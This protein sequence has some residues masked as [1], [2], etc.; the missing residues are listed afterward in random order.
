MQDLRTNAGECP[1]CHQSISESLIAINDFYKPM[2]IDQNIEFIQEQ[3]KIFNMMYQRETNS[4]EIQKRQIGSLKNHASDIRTAIRSLK[5]TL[6]SSNNSLSYATMEERIRLAEKIRYT[7]IIKAQ[8]DEL[9]GNF[10]CLAEEWCEVQSSLSKLPD[11]LLS[12]KDFSKIASLES[13]FQQQLKAYGFDSLNY[14]E[15]KIS[16]SYFPE[17]EGF[18]LQFNLSASDYIR[19]IWAYLLGMIEVS[20]EHT[21]NHLGLLI[22]DEPRQ[23]SAKEKSMGKF[24]FRAG[25]IKDNN[26]QIIIATS[27]SK[28][29]LDRCLEDIPH[30]YKRFDG[31][32]ISPM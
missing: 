8:I 2:T 26:Q 32:I 13:S 19:V 5:T 22:M 27:E 12:K 24:L 21:T 14:Q 9:L 17:Y 23:Q 29:I 4:L 25:S 16:E 7:K 11:G 1:T 10:S 31:K 15:V 6:I 3:L 28:E 30:T 20:Q 18:D